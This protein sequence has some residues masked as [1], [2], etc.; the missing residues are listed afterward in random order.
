MCGVA[1]IYAYHYASPGVDRNEL[2]QILRY[3]ASRGPDGEGEW[4]SADGRIGLGHKR[5][6]IIDLSD[7]AAQPMSTHDGRYV[8]SY[9]GEIYNYKELRARLEKKGYVFRS[10]SDTEVLLHLYADKG[11]AMLDDLRG[12]FAFALWDEHKKAVLLARDPYG[13]KPLYYADDGWTVRVASQVKALVSGGKVS[14]QPEPAGVV[15]FLLFGSV[16]EPFTT[17]QDI[18]AVPAGSYVWINNLGPSAPESYFSLAKIFRDA[19]HHSVQFGK[20]ELEGAVRDAL[21]DSVK[22]HLVSDVPV[23][24]FLSGGIDSG[25][26]VGLMRDAGQETIRTVTLAFEEFTGQPED[27]AI[28]AERAAKRYSTEHTTR[29]VTLN[30]FE[31]AIPEIVNAMDQLSI[32]GINT[33]FVSKA[34]RE[35]GL[36]V[37]ISGLGGDE[38]FAGYPSF[39]DIPRCVK[40]MTLP[41]RLPFVGDLSRIVL[42]SLLAVNSSHSPKIAGLIKYGGTYPGAYLL[43]RGIFMPWELPVVMGRE[44]AAEGLRRLAPLNLIRDAMRPDPIIPFARVATLES[45][46]YM[47]NQLLRDSDWAGMAHSVEIRTPLVD[48]NLLQNLTPVLTS[49]GCV[50]GKMLLAQSPRVPLD[51]SATNR[52]KTGFSL[53]IGSWLTR[54]NNCLDSWRRVPLLAREGCHWARRLAYSLQNE[55]TN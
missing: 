51:A 53:P 52:K 36:K 8:V 25:S 34:A 55:I 2:R 31:E 24:A 10:V 28:L 48:A 6:S 12:M 15:G 29:V 33:W 23:G 44:A 26:L 35:L 27:E 47:R 20:E 11:E 16:P 41:S 19:G 5:L 37:A 21:L 45:S 4:H 40:V 42:S 18:R 22:H 1:A 30:E 54:L 9:N 7:R 43:R 3:M 39:R 32:D 46:L 17:Y 50:Q 14:R 38:L 13:I 49:K